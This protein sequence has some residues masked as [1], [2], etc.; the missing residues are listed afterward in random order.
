MKLASRVLIFTLSLSLLFI[1][2]DKK[3]SVQEKVDKRIQ[4][5]LYTIRDTLDKNKGSVEEIYNNWLSSEMKETVS[6]EEYREHLLKRYQGK[7]GRELRTSYAELGRDSDGNFV[8]ATGQT[9]NVGRMATVMDGDETLKFKVRLVKESGKWLVEQKDLMDRILGQQ[10]E[11]E[12]LERLLATYKGLIK[13]ENVSARPLKKRKEEGWAEIQG[14]IL[15]ATEDFELTKVGVKVRFKDQNGNIVWI[16]EIYPVMNMRYLGLPSSV[17]PGEASAFEVKV[18]HIP[19]SWDQGQPLDFNF[20]HIDGNRMLNE[21]I[22]KEKQKRAKL[23]KEI[24][25]TK[26]AD[27]EARKQ[28]KKLWNREKALKNKIEEMK[29][30][31]KEENSQ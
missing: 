13:L 15:N 7:V 3:K 19:E 5:Y 14:V 10:K 16:S 11:K 27:E 12:R 8:L 6:L 1:S 21:E 9:S 28:L 17:L 30:K 18:R 26:Q 31:S 4:N 29:Q 22:E 23:R 24:Q 20:F 2:C 25:D